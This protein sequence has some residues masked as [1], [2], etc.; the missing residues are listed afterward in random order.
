MKEGVIKTKKK[1]PKKALT[2]LEPE[3]YESRLDLEQNKEVDI[4]TLIE[5]KLG[6]F[7]R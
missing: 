1:G 7:K 2:V 6:D 3:W 4:G 5:I